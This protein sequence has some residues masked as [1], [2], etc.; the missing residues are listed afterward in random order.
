MSKAESALTR[1]LNFN[2]LKINRAFHWIWFGQAVSITGSQLSAVSF[3]L[4][5]VTTLRATASQMG[6]LAA[7]QTF[8]YLCFGLFL[9]A[10]IDN[11]SR[12][13]LLI[14]SDILRSSILV[15]AAVLAVEK[16]LTI[17]LMWVIVCLT[18]TFNLVFD[19][20]LGAFIPEL[21]KPSRWSVANS[22]LSATVSAGEVTGPALAGFVV[23]VFAAPIAFLLDALSYIFSA[24][25]VLLCR[26]PSG[27]DSQM[28]K[29]YKAE[30]F[31]NR[32]SNTGPA[33]LEGL[34]F[35]IRH[36]I[37]RIFGLW[38][39][40]W[41]F[42]W[43]AVLAVLVLYASSILRIDAAS[44]GICYAVGGLGGVLGASLATSAARSFSRSGVMVY[45][46][47]VGAMGSTILLWS[48]NHPR[49]TLAASLFIFNV[50]QSAFG[51]NMQ[52]TRQLVTPASLM[53]RMDTTMRLCFTGMS[54]LGAL[55]GG[56]IGSRFGLH[57]SIV[58]GIA[59]LFVTA[60]GL[61]T[62]PLARLVS[63]RWDLIEDV[64]EADIICC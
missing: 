39:A 46:P 23:Q 6:I 1:A 25:C 2:L 45:A 18:A 3:Q 58:F 44:V 29:I 21:L 27:G 34:N 40:I 41:N 12:R 62:S 19:A 63:D 33:I 30:G 48:G 26:P 15:S 38:S 50:G 61:R 17:P 36:P 53:G 49:V 24:I 52:T 57:G 4:I 22:R 56:F 31:W 43:S 55:A 10:V 28:A 11:S 7:A 54:S 51:V 59:G 20:S 13:S 64:S 9:G 47:F 42:S 60:I 16:H 5:A 8:P 32:I 35:V 37:L 14:S